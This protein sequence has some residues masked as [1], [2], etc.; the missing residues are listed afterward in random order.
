MDLNS[1]NKL[2]KCYIWSITVRGMWRLNVDISE[3]KSEIPKK[4]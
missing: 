4:F 2:V 3:T 1:R